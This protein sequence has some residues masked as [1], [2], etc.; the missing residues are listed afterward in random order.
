MASWLT[1][2]PFSNF[3]RISHEALLLETRVWPLCSCSSLNGFVWCVDVLCFLGLK[4]KAFFPP[5]SLMRTDSIQF[6]LWRSWSRYRSRQEFFTWEYILCF[7]YSQSYY[8]IQYWEKYKIQVSE[9]PIS[10]YFSWKW[11]HLTIEA[12]MPTE[13]VIQAAFTEISR[14]TVL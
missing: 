9:A 7:S 5:F 14:R 6:V 3:C 8:S 11:R 2:L 10:K 13:L 1:N 12:H 4:H